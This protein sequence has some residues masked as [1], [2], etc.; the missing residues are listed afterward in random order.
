MLADDSYAILTAADVLAPN[1]DFWNIV[2]EWQIH[3]EREKSNGHGVI[4][5]MNGL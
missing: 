1:G 3:F 4:G 5:H 2:R